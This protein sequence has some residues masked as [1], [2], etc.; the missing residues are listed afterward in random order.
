[1]S[2][3]F[4]FLASL[5]LAGA[6]IALVYGAWNACVGLIE[7]ARVIIPLQVDQ[8]TQAQLYFDRGDGLR[9]ADS[10]VRTIEPDRALAE[11]EF[12][13]TG[14]RLRAFRFDPMTT[15]G[16]FTLG[17]PRLVDSRGKR[18]AIFS[19]EEISATNEISQLKVVNQTLFGTT[20]AGATDPQLAIRF[21]GPLRVST[22]RIPW[23]EAAA[24]FLLVLL[25]RR[26]LL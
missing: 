10:S 22:A 15:S 7:P 19:L 8:T 11:L 3:R 25:L 16:A 5:A 24:V 21:Q 13:I 18:I 17:Q 2:A 23:P 4:R 14:E 20:T 1:M 6:S 9:E 12:P 26:F